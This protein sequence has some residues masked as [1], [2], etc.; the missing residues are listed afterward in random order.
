M[1]PKRP[2]HVLIDQVRVARAGN[3]ATIDHADA[4]APTAHLTIGPGIAS[5]SDADIVCK[6]M[7]LT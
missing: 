3:E 7:D 1:R 4:G 6:S 5:M 2:T